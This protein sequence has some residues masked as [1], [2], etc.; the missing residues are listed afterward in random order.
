MSDS[1]T[2][3]ALA[4]SS[5]L[6]RRKASGVLLKINIPDVAQPKL[7]LPECKDWKFTT[8]FNSPIKIVSSVMLS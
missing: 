4:K 3:I 5:L 2:T 8:S 7:P 6:E 1:S